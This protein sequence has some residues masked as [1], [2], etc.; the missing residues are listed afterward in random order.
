VLRLRGIDGAAG[1]HVICL[2]GGT[3]FLVQPNLSDP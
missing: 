3:S 2:L 1:T